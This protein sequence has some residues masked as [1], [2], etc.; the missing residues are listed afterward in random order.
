MAQSRSDR[1]GWQKYFH[2]IIGLEDG[3]PR[4][5]TGMS[6]VARILTHEQPDAIVVARAGVTWEQEQAFC[7]VVRRGQ[8]ERREVKLGRAD[9]Q[10]YIVLDGLAPGDRVVVE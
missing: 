6:V 3:D 4:L 7:H 2:L 9:E 5:R 10:R 1:P 8:V